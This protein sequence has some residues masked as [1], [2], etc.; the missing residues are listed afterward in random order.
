VKLTR[1]DKMQSW[2]RVHSEAYTPRQDA[3][4]RLS[5]S[6]G[7]FSVV[8]L[9]CSTQSKPKSKTKVK[10]ETHR[11]E[12][13]PRHSAVGCNVICA[14]VVRRTVV[15]VVDGED[16]LV[17]VDPVVAHDRRVRHVGCTVDVNAFACRG[18]S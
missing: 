11:H 14:V 9:S 17:M 2:T 12:V 5:L 1:H 16:V 18:S 4:N 13:C 8:A 3:H 6:I 10:D 15:K 7:D